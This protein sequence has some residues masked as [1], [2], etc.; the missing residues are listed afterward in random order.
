MSGSSAES[1]AEKG[2]FKR[3]QVLS[4]SNFPQAANQSIDGNEIARIVLFVPVPS[5]VAKLMP[6]AGN[7]YGTRSASGEIV[8]RVGKLRAKYREGAEIPPR[9]LIRQPQTYARAFA[10][11]CV[12]RSA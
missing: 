7:R 5:L 3:R 8:R 11:E 9:T 1:S 6:A 2:I 12:D 4:S 10:V